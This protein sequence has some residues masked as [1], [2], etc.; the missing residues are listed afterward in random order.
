MAVE[1]DE[2][3]WVISAAAPEFGFCPGCGARSIRRHSRYSRHLQDL[4]AQGAIVAVK[5]LMTRWRCRN[6]ACERKTFSDELPGVAAR[7]ARRTLRAGRLLQLFAHGAGGKPSERLMQRLGMP[8]SDDTILRH[9]KR[10]AARKGKVN[11][12]VLG[13]DDWSWRKGESY[14]TVMVDLGRRE[15]VDVLPGR[16]AEATADWL[17]HH[18]QVEVISRDRCGLYAQGAREGAPKARQVAD[19]FHLLQNLREKIESQLSRS[20]RGLARPSLPRAEGEGRRFNFLPHAGTSS[21]R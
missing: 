10:G 1:R 13:I 8:A 9:L 17:R 11:V 20:D 15:V 7:Y 18:P 16:S 6:D 19:R 3:R 5:L 2:N 4:P 12:R 21:N 14:G